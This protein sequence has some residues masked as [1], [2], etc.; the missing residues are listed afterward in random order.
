ML[1]THSAPCPERDC[2]G[3]RLLLECCT[4][5]DDDEMMDFGVGSAGA[6]TVPS[7]GKASSSLS[8]SR[9]GRKL[10]ACQGMGKLHPPPNP[11]GTD[12]REAI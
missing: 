11:R 12:Q 5:L 9:S 8:P 3:K 6:I 7:R 4:S 2:S 1:I 10:L